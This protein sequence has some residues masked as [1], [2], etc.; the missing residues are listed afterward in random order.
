MCQRFR[1]TY[2][3]VCKRLP[4]TVAKGERIWNLLLEMQDQGFASSQ[5]W[6]FSRNEKGCQSQ[7]ALKYLFIMHVHSQYQGAKG[8]RNWSFLPEMQ[9]QGL[10]YHSTVIG[11][12]KARGTEV[13]GGFARRACLDFEAMAPDILLP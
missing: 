3:A 11:F 12:Q 4:R 5:F 1:V 13:T 2:S 7:D 6:S 8:K 10:L 9:V